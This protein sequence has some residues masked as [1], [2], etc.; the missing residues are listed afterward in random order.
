MAL[1]SSIVGGLLC[2][3]AGTAAAQDS[4]PVEPAPKIVR[5]VR[6]QTPP[7]IDGSLD[8][9]VW[10][11]AAVVDDLHQVLPFEFAEPYERTEIYLLYD[12]DALYVGARLY[13]T[14]PD[15]ITAQNMRQ[16]DSIFQDDS[17]FV[18]IDPFNDRRSGYFFGVNPNG[19]REDG[20]YQ[21]ITEFYS[22][23]DRA[24]GWRDR[25]MYA[26]RV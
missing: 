12:D 9:A 15:E 22:A 1:R 20:I 14:E 4:P 21:N 5:I 26:R 7:V 8:D 3:A 18:H 6:T 16:N 13:D 19:V 23:W 2:L 24:G 25:E 10:A 11:N 17:F